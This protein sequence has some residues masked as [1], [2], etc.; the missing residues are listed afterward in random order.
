MNNSDTSV[1]RL[2]R[3]GPSLRWRVAALGSL[4]IALLSVLAS[5]AVFWIVGSTLRGDQQRALRRDA[6]RVAAVYR[7]GGG[8]GVSLSGPTGGVTVQ[9]YDPQG[10]LFVASSPAFE[11]P[12]AALPS[13]VV[14]EA[15]VGAQDWRGQIGESNVQ[16]ALAPFD[17][18]VVAVLAD[19]S[20]VGHVLWRIGR[21][22]S[23]TVALLVIF[24]G[25]LGYFVAAAAI[26]PITDLAKL[27]ARLGPTRL[28]PVSY[29]G[30]DDEVG[31]LSR[32]LNELVARV[33][34]SIEG[35]RSFLAETSHELRTPLT[36]LQGF[37]ARALRGAGP[38]LS[39]DIRDAARIAGGM[40]RLVE[41]LLELSRGELLQEMTPHLIDPW[42][43][44][45]KPVAEEFPGIRLDGQ[46]G[47]SVLGD[48]DRLRQLIRNLSANAVRAAGDPARVE[49]DL[50]R[51]KGFVV[52]IVRDDGPGIPKE[53]Q[54]LVFNKFYKGSSGGVG[55]GLAIAQQIAEQHGGK[56]LVRSRP[57]QTVFSTTLPALVK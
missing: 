12:R 2:V 47:T 9:L 45:L 56:I 3:S 25:V 18:G 34:V 27:A 40:S 21:I 44:I 4:T 41:D 57:G 29:E 20:F 8:A 13:E 30:P 26:K 10:V 48:P 16:V 33:K 49:L 7:G 5:L 11:H 39:D 23:F 55:L 17:M 6:A 1:L 31:K 51:V 38:E 42:L 14:L 46:P 32:V 54:P 43:D 22:L 15:L 28:D 37:L 19:M 50:E 52:L 53:A 24:G 36:S 35:Q